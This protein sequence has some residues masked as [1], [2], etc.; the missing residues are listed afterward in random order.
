MP[1]SISLPLISAVDT[2]DFNLECKSF[3]DQLKTASDFTNNPSNESI[4]KNEFLSDDDAG[5]T[6]DYEITHGYETSHDDEATDLIEATHLGEARN[7][8]EATNKDKAVLDYVASQEDEA[9][10]D[11]GIK[12]VDMEEDIIIVLDKNG[13]RNY[14]KTNESGAL[15]QINRDEKKSYEIVFR[16][17]EIGK[18]VINTIKEM[19][20]QKTR[21]VRSPM[22]YIHCSQCMAKYRFHA[23]LKDHMKA[24]HDVDLYICRVCHIIKQLLFGF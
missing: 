20:P 16:N 1:I 21:K 4:L 18:N 2:F 11:G 19:R 10:H 13:K 7:N 5:A 3:A 22:Q 24:D 14:Y 23:R 17:T 15:E 6:H 9:T 12:E 8:S